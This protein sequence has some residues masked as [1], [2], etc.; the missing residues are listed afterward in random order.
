VRL[1]LRR[2]SSIL[3]AI[4]AG[5]LLSALPNAPADQ[6]RHQAAVNLLAM[7]SEELETLIS[8]LD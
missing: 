5:E 4:D 2:L 1:R 3:T 6:T 8:D 7:L